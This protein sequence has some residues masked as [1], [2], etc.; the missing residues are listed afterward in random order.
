MTI[1]SVLIVTFFVNG[2]VYLVAPWSFAEQGVEDG[3]FFSGIYT[4]FTSSWFQVI[5]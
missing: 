2:I 5:G 1:Y 3:E 4:E